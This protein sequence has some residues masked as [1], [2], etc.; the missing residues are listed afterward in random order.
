MIL[1]TVMILSVTVDPSCSSNNKSHV[2]ESLLA[3]FNLSPTLIDLSSPSRN[4]VKLAGVFWADAGT[5]AEI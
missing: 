1:L 4:T 5:K 3:I 2:L